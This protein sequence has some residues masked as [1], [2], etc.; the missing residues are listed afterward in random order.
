[1]PTEERPVEELDTEARMAVRAVVLDEVYAAI[2][3]LY[4]CEGH[5]DPQEAAEC[6]WER[7]GEAIVEAI[8]EDV[9]H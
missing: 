2:R 8:R 5:K 4:G 6:M 7:H 1:M 9:D 3:A